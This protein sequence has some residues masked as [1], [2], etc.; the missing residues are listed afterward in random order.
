MLSFL[1]KF[2]P[3]FEAL[4]QEPATAPPSSRWARGEADSKGRDN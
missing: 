1:E 3:E 4:I 2:R